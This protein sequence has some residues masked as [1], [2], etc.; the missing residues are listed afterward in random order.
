MY[1]TLALDQLIGA[2]S[3]GNAVVLKPSNHALACS[4]VLANLIPL[5]MDS[6]AIQVIEGGPQICEKFLLHKWDKIFFT[7]SAQIGRIV[8]TAAAKHLTPVTLE[9]GG[10]CPPY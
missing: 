10:K 6:K 3:A 2:I 1:V 5:Y 7:G 9:L 4:S 8:M